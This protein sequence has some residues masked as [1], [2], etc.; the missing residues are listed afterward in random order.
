[1]RQLE[2]VSVKRKALIITL[3]FV[4]LNC[5]SIAQ[6][7][8]VR[9]TEKYSIEVYKYALTG[10][11]GA[12]QPV[13]ALRS[14]I[15]GIAGQQYSDNRD[16]STLAKLQVNPQADLVNV[17]KVQDLWKSEDVLEVLWGEIHTEKTPQTIVSHVYVGDLANSLENK[18][19]F[20][21]LRSTHM[22]A[23]YERFCDMHAALALYLLATNA[24]RLGASRNV[25]I[26]YLA[27]AQSLLPKPG[28][29]SPDADTSEMEVSNLVERKRKE[30]SPPEKKP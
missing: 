7:Q 22:P 14:V 1:V 16:L 9:A 15:I 3:F 5:A 20:L 17:Q 21:T 28:S 8:Q 26:G 13:D 30:L 18:N 11:G 10:P 2:Q 24:E 27:I 12:N 6:T 19:P 23:D 4:C 25:T 29:S